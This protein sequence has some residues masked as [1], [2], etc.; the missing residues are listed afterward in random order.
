MRIRYLQRSRM[1]RKALRMDTVCEGTGDG[2][3]MR[4][5]CTFLH[6]EDAFMDGAVSSLLSPYT[7]VFC[8]TL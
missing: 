6:Q 1:A 4:K 8:V 2:I 7:V 5:S 3:L